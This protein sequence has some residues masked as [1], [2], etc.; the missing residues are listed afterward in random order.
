MAK[1]DYVTTIEELNN[2]IFLLRIVGKKY[3]RVIL[4]WLQQLTEREYP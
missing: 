3:A 2:V 1:L 4:V